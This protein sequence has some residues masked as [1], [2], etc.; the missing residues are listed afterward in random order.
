MAPGS[1]AFTAYLATMPND[2]VDGIQAFASHVIL[3]NGDSNDDA[4]LQPKEPVQVPDVDKEESHVDTRTTIQEDEGAM[5]KFG[6]QDLVDLHLI[7]NDQQPTTLSAQDELIQWHHHLGHLPF[8]RIRSMSQRGI[9]PKWRLECTKPFCAACQYGMLTRKPW[10]SK[11]GP[12]NPIRRATSSRQIISINQL[13]SSTVGFI[14]QLKGKLTT[15]RYRYA[16]VFVDQHSW[17]AYVYLQW[18]IT[19]ASPS[20]AQLRAHG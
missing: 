20:Q 19:R 14:A 17:Y 18:T 1:E 7:P 12:T 2:R 9:L 10:R 11:G 6:M 8:D 5:T 15:Q 4:S 13:E 3:D 16:T